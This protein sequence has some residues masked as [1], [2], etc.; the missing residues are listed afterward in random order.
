[1]DANDIFDEAELK[2]RPNEFDPAA[3]LDELLVQA[4][5]NPAY[6][7]EFLRALLREPLYVLVEEEVDLDRA[8]GGLVP[9]RPLRY[10]DGVVPVFTSAA[11]LAKAPAA[12]KW[13][14]VTVKGRNLME[15]MPEADFLVNPYAAVSLHLKAAY[16]QQV[17]TQ[18]GAFRQEV[19]PVPEE[20][21]MTIGLP[22]KYPPGLVEALQT[23]L[24]GQPRVRAAYLV[25]VV[26]S[27]VGEPRIEVYLDVEGPLLR[28]AQ[29][30]GEVA[31][32]FAT[33]EVRRVDILEAVP[34]QSP[35]TNYA[36]S[37]PP[38]YVRT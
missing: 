3:T 14:H 2:P 27:S 1:M 9:F 36:L 32:C 11:E 16:L 13:P 4:N 5:A 20:E 8:V 33:D 24:S 26:K 22:E 12:A 23:V 34:D 21:E 18:G 29:D 25:Y 19:S 35:L 37:T 6:R 10:Q 31:C 15:A 7:P 30:V 17:L 38:I 28:I